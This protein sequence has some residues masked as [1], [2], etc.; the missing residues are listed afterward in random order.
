MA[1]LPT[2]G[3]DDGTWGTILN[4]FL[5]VS[6]DGSTGALLTSAVQD[7][8]GVT[9][10][11]GV[12]P[13]S[14]AVTLTAANVGA[15]SINTTAGNIAALGTRAAGGVGTAA[16]AGHVHP[17]TGLVLQ[18][19]S[20]MAG[21]LAPAVV[22]LGSVSG[23]VAVNAAL[24]NVFALTL[25]G[26]VTISTP[27]TPLDGQLIR[28]RITQGSSTTVSFGTGYIFGTAGAPTFS[29]T[30]GDVDVIAFEYNGAL[31][32]WCYFGAGLGFVA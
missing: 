9:S 1:G 20:T 26:S 17:T 27:T 24:G 32:K 13:S 8:G 11:N 5:E 16:D 31:G 14:G 15:A 6:H 21:W 7:A 19:G 28:F 18:S 23:T 3:G 30:A 25:T 29:T 10:V 22:S 12:S 2:P 4:A